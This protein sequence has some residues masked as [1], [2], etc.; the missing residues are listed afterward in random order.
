MKRR[1]EV[2]GRP[3]VEVGKG[4]TLMG[5]ADVR[6][7]GERDGGLPV[8]LAAT[9]GSEA[10]LGVGEHAVRLAR[11]MGAKLVVLYVVDE[12]MAFRAGIHHGDAV[13]E[14]V[15]A[16]REATK[17]V[18]SLAAGS[19]VECREMVV[20]GEPYRAIVALADELGTEYVVLG[21]HGGSAFERA[22]LGSVS[23]KVLHL[24]NRPVLVVGGGNAGRQK[25]AAER[26]A[27]RAGA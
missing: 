10:S 7:G 21:S 18:A 23:G 24:S 9:D 15:R 4:G 12:D 14:L 20:Y 8:I 27:T 2:S 5:I 19:G 22:I 16:G 13:A 25:Q 26:P 11:E 17:K 3:E 6:E 1:G